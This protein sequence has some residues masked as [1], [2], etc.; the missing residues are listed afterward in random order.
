VHNLSKDE[1]LYMIMSTSLLGLPSLEMD[2]FWWHPSGL[3]FWFTCV[4]GFFFGCKY[5]FWGKD[6]KGGPW[7]SYILVILFEII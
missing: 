7:F 6:I 2:M 1:Q 3:I 5:L 4:D